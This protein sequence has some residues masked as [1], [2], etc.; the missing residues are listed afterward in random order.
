MKS[1][2]VLEDVIAYPNGNDKIS[3]LKGSV[4]E[5]EPFDAD[6]FLKRGY[7]EEVKAKPKKEI[8]PLKAKKETKPLKKKKE[9]K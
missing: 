6:F 1:I 9:S 7:A 3:L 8:K 4:L 2:K 5:M